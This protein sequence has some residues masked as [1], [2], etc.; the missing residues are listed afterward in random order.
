[1]NQNTELA[2]ENF[3]LS[4]ITPRADT[5]NTRVRPKSRPRV[6]LGP[7]QLRRTELKIRS[8]MPLQ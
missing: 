8:V 6:A 7:Q 2:I 3:F 5:K 4:F 1:M